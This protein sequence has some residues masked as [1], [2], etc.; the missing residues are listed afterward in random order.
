MYTSGSTGRPKGV[1]I[2]H[3]G[4]VNGV[5]RLA[6][7]LGVRAGSRMLGATSINFDVS[8]SEMFTALSH[9]ACVDVVRDVL[10]LTERDSWTGGV[11]Q[12]VPSVF[13]EILD[14]IA[15]RTRVDTVVLAGDG[16]P[17]TLL[18]RM[19]TAMPHTRLVQAYGQT[20]DFYATSYVV[21]DGWSGEGNV[22]IGRPLGNM[23][24][25]V[26]GSGL[27]PVPVGVTGELYV[28]GAIGRGY[29]GRPGLTAER[30][31]ADP[32]GRPGDR[33]YRTGDLV[34]WNSDGQLEYVGRSDA[35]MK[36]RGFRIEPGEIEAAVVA[37]PGVAKAVVQLRAGQASAA[38]QLVGYVVP[39][40][41]EAD[42]GADER[43]GT[44]VETGRLDVDDLLRFVSG[45][46]PEFMVPAAFIVL[47]RFP[48]DPNGKLDRRALPDPQFAER[49]YRE[50][51]TS[52]E[53]ALCAVF[54]EVLGLARVGVDDDFFAVGGDSIRSI[55]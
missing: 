21:P 50:P 41:A 46:L 47:D 24:T 25:Y 29:H 44:P 18:E 11:V 38:E 45:R 14:E 3:G 2:T 28:A 15:D 53:Q 26:L 9:G 1:A 36:I 7:V 42:A 55:Q 48:L 12:A 20:E 17:A 37:H 30:F 13:S 54:G 8:A 16:L 51:R 32:F 31:L 23:R 4:L 35:Q 19:R 40:D 43:T 10:E 52:Q 49:S 5:L 6:D 22:P 34:R 27:V 39:V 33:M